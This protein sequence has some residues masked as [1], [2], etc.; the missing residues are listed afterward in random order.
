M[1]LSI[2]IFLFILFKYN[3]LFKFIFGVSCPMCGM[4]RA[5][6]SALTFDFKSA[7]YFHAFWPF[8]I[9]FVIIFALLKFKVLRINKE[10]IFMTL[11]VFSILNLTYYFY[12]L[13]IGSSI[14]NYNFNQSLL[15][16]IYFIIAKLFWYVN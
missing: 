7:F 3:C 9:I 11:M 16:K 1:I 8:I 2:I 14:V 4:T 10:Y 12:R 15:H 6:I 13:S 5:I